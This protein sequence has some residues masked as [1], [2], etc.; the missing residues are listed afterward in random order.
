VGTAK[1]DRK[2]GCGGRDSGGQRTGRTEI[3]KANLGIDIV[4]KLERRGS[5][6]N[7]GSHQKGGTKSFFVRRSRC[8]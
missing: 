5:R 6:V 2:T 1:N 8:E 4:G 3:I 7:K